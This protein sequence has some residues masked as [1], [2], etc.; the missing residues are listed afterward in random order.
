MVLARIGDILFASLAL[1]FVGPLLLAVVGLLY[2]AD[3]GPVLVA[4]HQRRE[5]GGRVS[6]LKFRAVG[7]YAEQMIETSDPP[8]GDRIGEVQPDRATTLKKIGIFLHKSGVDEVPQLIDVLR[9]QMAIFA[10]LAARIKRREW[11]AVSSW[12]NEC[13]HRR[14][15]GRFRRVGVKVVL[16]EEDQ[17]GN[18]RI[19]ILSAPPT[20]RAKRGAAWDAGSAWVK[21]RQPGLGE[22]PDQTGR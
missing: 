18:R 8:S 4:H 7:A 12:H 10:R 5:N 19:R 20:F 14:I 13:I 11:R 22:S 21:A 6:R 17:F 16:G 3:G 1:V 15:D 9:G 2:L